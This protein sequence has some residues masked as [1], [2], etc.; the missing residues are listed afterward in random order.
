MRPLPAHTVHFIVDGKPTLLAVI[1]DHL[2]VAADKKLS[3]MGVE[4]LD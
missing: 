2:V 1:I 3:L 4:W